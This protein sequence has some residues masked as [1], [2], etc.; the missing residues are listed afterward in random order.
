MLYMI[1]AGFKSLALT[2][3]CFIAWLLI[4]SLIGQK[5]PAALFLPKT[6]GKVLTVA[7]SCYID[8]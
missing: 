2:K 4:L 5:F 6:I 8:T 3:Y 1:L 7:T